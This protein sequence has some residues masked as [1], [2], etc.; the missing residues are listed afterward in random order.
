MTRP[1]EG[2][3]AFPQALKVEEAFFGSE[4]MSLRDY[5]AA[6]ALPAVYAGHHATGLLGTTEAIA[7][8][9]YQLADAMLAERKKD[10]P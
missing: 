4:G 3:A 7:A 9:A 10:T 5:F 2:A 8:D 1:D 6:Q